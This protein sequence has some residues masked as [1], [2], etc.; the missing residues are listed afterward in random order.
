MELRDIEIFLALAEELH[1]GRT[2]ERLH[3]TPSRISHTIKRQERRIGAPLFERT[4]RVV[5]LTPLGRQLRDELL[6]AHQQIQAAVERATA[7]AHGTTGTLRVG[8]TTPWCADLVLRAGE[9]FGHLHPGWTVQIREVQF[10]DPYGP[11]QRGELDLQLVEFPAFGSIVAGPVLFREPRAL[12]VPAGHPLASRESVTLEDLADIPIVSLRF[13]LPRSAE[14]LHLPRYTPMGR[15]VRRGPSY[16]YWP[17][18]PALVAAGLGGSIVAARAA[19]F[20]ARP[21]IAFVPFQDGPTID[22]T[23]LWHTDVQG[24]PVPPF[25]DLLRELAGADGGGADGPG[26]GDGAG[27]GGAA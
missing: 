6:P 14:D 25:V 27:G 19:Q 26:D 8:Y 13:E 24:P 21:G 12:M 17:E 9:R 22:Y 5:R 20:H 16:T 23:V 1:F 11:L 7:R 10:D 4:S 3:V 15:P 18:V 2:A